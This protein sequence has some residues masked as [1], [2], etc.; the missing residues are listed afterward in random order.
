MSR[1]QRFVRRLQA[2][3]RTNAESTDSATA[4]TVA[5]LDTLHNT[6]FR[7]FC[8]FV[9]S[10]SRLATWKS[11]NNLAAQVPYVDAYEKIRAT[12]SY[13]ILIYPGC[14]G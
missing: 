4:G 1:V 5:R 3:E 2:L 13:Q 8:Q 11:R 14:G 7:G 6:K 12:R 9:C 10:P